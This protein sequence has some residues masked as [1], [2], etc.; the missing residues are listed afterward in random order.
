[1]TQWVQSRED[2]SFDAIT[3]GADQDATRYAHHLAT[4][5]K[6][7]PGINATV[8]LRPIY[9]GGARV[10]KTVIT[11]IDFSPVSRKVSATEIEIARDIG[12]RAVVLNAK[13]A[14]VTRR[15]RSGLFQ[16]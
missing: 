1:M 6:Q 10:M 11:A 2:I 8:V 16:P 12:R 15:F 3:S 9:G 4:S 14:R 7:R 13:P 5:A